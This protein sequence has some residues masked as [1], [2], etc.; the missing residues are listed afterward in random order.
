MIARL[1]SVLGYPVLAEGLSPVRNFAS[2]QPHLIQTYDAILRNADWAAQ[3]APEIVIRIGEM[4]IS[5]VLRAWLAQV[6]PQT[7][8]IDQTPRSIDPIHGRTRQILASIF[9][10]EVPLQAE[11]L[12]GIDPD[13]STNQPQATYLSNLE[14]GRIKTTLPN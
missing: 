11:N 5:K 2:L 14:N 8:I 10:L 1:S 9:D 6:Q 12:A 13:Q 7:W 3:L 4:P